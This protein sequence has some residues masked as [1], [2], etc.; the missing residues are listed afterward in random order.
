MLEKLHKTDRKVCR[1]WFSIS[2]KLN[3]RNPNA[4][5]ITRLGEKA[6]LHGLDLVCGVPGWFVS[7]VPLQTRAFLCVFGPQNTSGSWKGLFQTLW[8]SISRSTQVSSPACSPQK[9]LCRTSEL[10]T[11]TPL[12]LPVEYVWCFIAP[13][14]F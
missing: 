8:S 14:S 5:R 2:L 3:L 7:P 10:I 4:V 13:H 1:K 12:L 6:I 11:S 9:L